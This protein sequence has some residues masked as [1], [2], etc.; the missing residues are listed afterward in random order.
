M[1]NQIHQQVEKRFQTLVK[2][3]EALEQ[4]QPVTGIDIIE[5][6][7]AKEDSVRR[8]LDELTVLA[9][10]AGSAFYRKVEKKCE[11]LRMRMS[12][13]PWFP[14]IE[15]VK[16]ARNVSAQH[17]L[18]LATNNIFHMPM[19]Q[20]VLKRIFLMEDTGI[21]RFDY[22]FPIVVSQATGLVAFG[23]AEEGNQT[24]PLREL[25]H[26]AWAEF[27]GIVH[28]RYIVAYDFPNAQLQLVMAAHQYG[29]SIPIL[30]GHSFTDILL[31]YARVKDVIGEVQ[32]EEGFPIPDRQLC[33]LLADEDVTPFHPSFGSA[34]QQAKHLLQ[35]LQDMANGTLSL[36]QPLPMSVLTDHP[37][38]FQPNIR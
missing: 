23:E 10:Q 21:T 22:Q 17:P 36:Q 30:V 13:L 34:D 7:C 6:R 38:T 5:Q 28:G 19:L 14:S 12:L 26:S 35:A 31:K 3:V 4:W 27:L 15:G 16:L 8:Q 2:E 33:T 18:I 20:P 9:L 37:F 29:L 25:L 11:S 24:S 1:V 32:D